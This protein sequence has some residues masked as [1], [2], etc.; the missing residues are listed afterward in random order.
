MTNLTRIQDEKTKLIKV[1][2]INGLN[3][4]SVEYNNTFNKLNKALNYNSS[5]TK[6]NI[7]TGD[8]IHTC[9]FS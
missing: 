5:H 6:R 7:K 8:Y 3:V 4:S 9:I 2:Q 1:Y